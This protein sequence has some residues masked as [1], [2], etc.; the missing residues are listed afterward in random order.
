MSLGLFTSAADYPDSFQV[1]VNPSSFRVNQPVDLTVKAIKKGQVMKNYEGRFFIEIEGN[2]IS[3]H[4]Y[5]VPEDGFGE[6]KLTNQGTKTYSKGLQIKKAGTFSLK[7]SD[8]IL[9]EIVG[10]AT[11]IVSSDDQLNLKTIQLL[12]PLQNGK[13]TESVMSVM[14]TAPELSNSRIQIFLNDLMVKEGMTDPN[15]LLNETIP[16]TKA[17]TNVLELKALALNNQIVGISDKRTF[18][19]EPLSDNLFKSI[20]MTPNQNLKL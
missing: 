9:D 1:E 19:Y 6:M 3:P 2:G 12:S 4:D 7:I 8:F 17:G 15:G 18:L 5:T 14:A 11:I 20:A 13:E 16:L 10:S